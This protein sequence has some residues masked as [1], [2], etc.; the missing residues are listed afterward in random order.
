MAGMSLVTGESVPGYIKVSVTDDGIGIPSKD[1]PRI[2]DRFFQVEFAS[3]AAAWRYGPGTLCCKSYDRNARRPNLGR[4]FGGEGK[5]F[6]VPF[7]DQSHSDRD[8]VR[9]R[10]CRNLQLRKLKS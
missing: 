10:L 1:L 2:F 3:H 6:P 9:V 7:A 8:P 4:K 5:Q